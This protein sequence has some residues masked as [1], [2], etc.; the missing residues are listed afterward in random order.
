MGKKRCCSVQR[1]RLLFFFLL[2]RKVNTGFLEGERRL[3]LPCAQPVSREGGAP[4]LSQGGKIYM[5][6][7]REGKRK[8]ESERESLFLILLFFATLLIPNNG[9]WLSRESLFPHLCASSSVLAMEGDFSGFPYVSIVVVQLCVFFFQTS[10]L[11]THNYQFPLF[12]RYGSP[13]PPLRYC[14]C[15]RPTRPPFAFNGNPAMKDS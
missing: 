10:S 2:V 11:I 12:R 3:L 15:H 7:P 6:Y 1:P 14:C 9:A 4:S 8:K 5:P 13:P